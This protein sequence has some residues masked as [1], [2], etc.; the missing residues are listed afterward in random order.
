MNTN[1]PNQ[2]L[3]RTATRFAFTF[4]WLN[5]FRFERDS[6]PVA[7]A[8]LVL[9]RSMTRWQIATVLLLVLSSCQTT[10]PKTT[11]VAHGQTYCAIHRIPLVSAHGYEAPAGMFMHSRHPRYYPCEEKYP[12]HIWATRSL[13]RSNIRRVSAV[14]SYCPK[15]EEEFWRC[16]GER[17]A[18]RKDLT[19]RWSQ[20]LA[21]S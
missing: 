3:E 4:A 2:A 17:F 8:Q 10:E 5:P 14:F 15:C 9:V 20:P 13:Y 19:N 11:F 12:N 7:V 16:V 6:L 18:D 1:R 21:G